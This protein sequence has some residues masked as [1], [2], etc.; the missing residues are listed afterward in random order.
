MNWD[1]GWNGVKGGCKRGENG[2]IFREQAPGRGVEPKALSDK[3]T[4]GVYPHN[5]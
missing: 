1:G 5:P 4:M 2:V 3:G